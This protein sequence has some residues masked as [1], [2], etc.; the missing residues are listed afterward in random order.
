MP[1][2]ANT[3]MYKLI[4]YDCPELLYIG[5]TTNFVKRKQK[6][7][8]DSKK[9]NTKIYRTIRE[10]G[11][12]ESWNMIKISDYPCTSLTESHMEEDRLMMEMKS[13]LNMVKAYTSLEQR[14]EYCKQY[15]EN[16]REHANEYAKQY[17]ENKKEQIA[18]YKSEKI[19]CECGCNIR[20]SDISTHKKTTKHQKAIAL[21]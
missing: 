7:K 21:L 6:H 14:Q 18:K 3:L 20:R 15:R 13:N 12:W 2:Y 11:G 1:N 5:S 9:S 8:S 17:R 4:N 19:L 10:N 16:N